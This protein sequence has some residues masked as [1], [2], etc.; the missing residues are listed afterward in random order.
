MAYLTP[1][2]HCIVSILHK[3]IR[4]SFKRLQTQQQHLV[5]IQLDRQLHGRDRLQ[6]ISIFAFLHFC[7]SITRFHGVCAHR[8]KKFEGNF[9]YQA[10]WKGTGKRGKV[11]LLYCLYII[12]GVIAN[13]C[14]SS[15]LSKNFPIILKCI[16]YNAAD[17]ILK[18]NST[19]H[20]GDIKKGDVGY[21]Q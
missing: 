21:R 8:L 9:I 11:Y 2:L 19:H 10:I 16:H 6:K 18:Q 14:F 3:N 4:G 13:R 12:E 20:R 17:L 15:Y 7:L 5:Q 1:A